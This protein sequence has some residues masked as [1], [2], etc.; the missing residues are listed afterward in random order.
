MFN[1]YQKYVVGVSKM[2]TQKENKLVK[3]HTKTETQ[4]KQHRKTHT[5]RHIKTGFTDFT[6]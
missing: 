1:V 3:K 6:G 2:F 5:E 4:K